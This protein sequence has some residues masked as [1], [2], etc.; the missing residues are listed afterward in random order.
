MSS[1][2]SLLFV[3]SL[4]FLLHH[5]YLLYV[6]LQSLSYLSLH[7]VASMPVCFDRS[8]AHYRSFDEQYLEFICAHQPLPSTVAHG[9]RIHV[10]LSPSTRT[11]LKLYGHLFNQDSVY[12]TIC[13]M[14]FSAV[15]VLLLQATGTFQKLQLLLLIMAC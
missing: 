15:M 4:E 6:S 3:C 2:I 14:G 1:L 11:G 7:L 5:Y 9:T 8:Q 12:K 10:Q 13:E